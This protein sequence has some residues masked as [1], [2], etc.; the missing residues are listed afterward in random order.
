MYTHENLDC[1]SLQTVAIVFERMIYKQMYTYF[2]EKN[3]IQPW[4][5][6]FKMLYSTVTALLDMANEWCFNIDRGMVNG[7]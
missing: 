1:H 7:L 4:R 6:G 2:T 3:I 5:S